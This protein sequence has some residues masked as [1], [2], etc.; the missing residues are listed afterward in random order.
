YYF[1]PDSPV[2]QANEAINREIIGSNPFYIVVEGDAPGAI[3]R[4]E[5]LKVI[6]DLQEFLGKLTG[7]TS[8]ISVVDYLETLEVAAQPE[9]AGAMYADEHGNPVP[10]EPAWSFWDE[11][12]NLEPLLDTMG[13]RPETFKSVVTPDF[14]TAS[15]LV[16]TNLSGSRRVE[17]TL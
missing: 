13:K 14:S 9:R 6:K 12:K 15:I 7:V 4:W 11:P 1:E 5:V 2:R 17:E 10:I 8:S 3:R 16:R